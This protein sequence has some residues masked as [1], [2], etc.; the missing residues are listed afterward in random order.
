MIAP[1]AATPHVATLG[2]APSRTVTG[3]GL[4]IGGHGLDIKKLLLF[5]AAGAAAGVFL[6]VIPGGPIGGALIGAAL[7]LVL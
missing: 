3:G 5:G 4:H 1:T 2:L 6:P 7:A